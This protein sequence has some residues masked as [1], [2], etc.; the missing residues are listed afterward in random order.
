[1]FVIKKRD[2]KANVSRTI[3]FNEE[4]YNTLKIIA[5]EEEI[6]FNSLVLQCCEFALQ[7][8]K[9]EINNEI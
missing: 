6:S 9:K 7:N 1:M 3:R 8:K 2:S 4:L 5:H